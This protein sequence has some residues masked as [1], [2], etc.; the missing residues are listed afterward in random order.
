MKK[1][2][3]ISLAVLT[4]FSVSTTSLASS[5]STS[6]GSLT[7]GQGELVYDEATGTLPYD[8][9]T[10]VGGSNKQLQTLETSEKDVVSTVNM[11]GNQFVSSYIKVLHFFLGRS[12]VNPI[13]DFSP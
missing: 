12:R 9:I 6:N 11:T 7:I 3:L 2:S 13:G 8:E 1:L 4:A 5:I 10:I